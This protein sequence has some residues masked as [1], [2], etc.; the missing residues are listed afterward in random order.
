MYIFTSVFKEKRR[1]LQGVIF[2]ECCP[3]SRHSI[4]SIKSWTSW[5]TIPHYLA[6][7]QE[8]FYR[9]ENVIN[10]RWQNLTLCWLSWAFSSVNQGC[11]HLVNWHPMKTHGSHPWRKARCH[12]SASRLRWQV[13]TDL[14]D[15]TLQKYVRGVTYY[16][17]NEWYA[18]EGDIS[19]LSDLTIVVIYSC[20]VLNLLTSY[21]NN[22]LFSSQLNHAKVLRV[23]SASKGDEWEEKSG[24]VPCESTWGNG[25]LTSGDQL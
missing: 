19:R 6:H 23:R 14:L 11:W 12:F 21:W 22:I 15:H 17:G 18:L 13:Q 1:W 9:W 20:P 24:S 7:K 3:V 4:H 16:R 2:S 25:R 8:V 10:G 5:V